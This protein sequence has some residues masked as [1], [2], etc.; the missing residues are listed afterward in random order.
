MPPA[1]VN[2]TAL[3]AIGQG[4]RDAI[5]GVGGALVGA[6]VYAEA[7]PF[8]SRTLEP[9]GKLGKV[10]FADVT[11]ASPWRFIAGLAIVAVGLLPL[12]ALSRQISG[13]RR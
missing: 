8:L 12:I 6:A 3:A 7:Y 9:I 2:G 1:I 13:I 10:T 4:S 5:V 11:H